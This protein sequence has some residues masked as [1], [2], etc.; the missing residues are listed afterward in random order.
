MS[1][2]P[3]DAA[4]WANSRTMAAMGGGPDAPATASPACLSSASARPSCSAALVTSARASASFCSASA[5]A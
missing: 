3:A 5:A 2:G 4:R 1:A